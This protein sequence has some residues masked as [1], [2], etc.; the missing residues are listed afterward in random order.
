M[1]HNIDMIEDLLSSFEQGDISNER[2]LSQLTLQIDNIPAIEKYDATKKEA[3]LKKLVRI[4]I[5]SNA[6]FIN[7]YFALTIIADL[8][9]IPG[10]YNMT[11]LQL[12]CY[13]GNQ[14]FYPIL[15]ELVKYPDAWKIRH[16]E[17]GNT[18]LHM[19]IS[20]FKNY[21]EPKFEIILKKLAQFPELWIVRNNY[22]YTPLHDLCQY[23]NDI[24]LNIISDFT[25]FPKLWEVENMKSATPLHYFC[26]HKPTEQNA[27]KYAEIFIQLA[28]HTLIWEI[29]DE[30]LCTPL[31]LF[32]KHFSGTHYDKIYEQLKKYPYLW[33]I[34]NNREQVPGEP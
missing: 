31:H 2:L 19:L 23:R 24:I 1:A 10:R 18:A 15:D 28:K 3:L 8:W 29:Q 16:A 26:L 14:L 17:H 12:T 33:E 11:M 32:C 34:R 5:E 7:L 4:P 30:F 9:K 27:T 20:N 6:M 25:Q 13:N 22:N 21:G